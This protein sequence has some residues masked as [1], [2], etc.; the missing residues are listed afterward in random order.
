[1]AND[2]ERR[3]SKVERTLD[4]HLPNLYAFIDELRVFTAQLKHDH[5]ESVLRISQNEDQIRRIV[6]SQSSLIGTMVKLSESQDR[7]VESQ[8][9]LI[10]TQGD[11]N[12][13]LRGMKELLG[14]H[15]DRLAADRYL[16]PNLGDQEG[17]LGKR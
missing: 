8:N 7:L 16:K 14:N 2:F 4:E 10:D 13:I 11:T 17:N 15:G 9:R 12:K 3:M 1:M 6:D 5:E